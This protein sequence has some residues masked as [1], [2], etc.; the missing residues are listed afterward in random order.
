MKIDD[1]HDLP[2]QF[3]FG[4]NISVG[5]S[6]QQFYIQKSED[7]FER[8]DGRLDQNIVMVLTKADPENVRAIDG[9][10]NCFGDSGKWENKRS[11]MS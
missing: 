10:P 9:G 3:C 7:K 5:L 8:L 2:R 6:R 1:I 4:K 11:L